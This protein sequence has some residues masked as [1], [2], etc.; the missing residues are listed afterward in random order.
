[1]KITLR[2]ITLSIVA[3]LT[4]GCQKPSGEATSMEDLTKKAT[5]MKEKAEAAAA[6]VK[7]KA[8]AAATAV[9]EA[10]K[11]ATEAVET[12][13]ESVDGMKGAVTGEAV[14]SPAAEMPMPTPEA[15]P[16]PPAEAA[17]PAVEMP[18]VPDTTPA[19]AEP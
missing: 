9:Q 6:E 5:E 17:P 3:G 10:T 15:A 8:E 1:M 14:P 19:P 4:V 18:A 12:V 2:F 7:E 11:Q 16:A 13:K